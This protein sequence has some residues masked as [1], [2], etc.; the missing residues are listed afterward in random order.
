MRKSADTWPRQ[1]AGAAKHHAPRYGS[2]A[3]PELAVDEVPQAPGGEAERH[4]RRD[5]IHEAQVIDAMAP[6]GERHG[7]HHTEQPAVERHAA[8]PDGEDLERMRGVVRRL[9][10]EHVAQPTAEDHAENG[11]EDEIVELRA[12]DWRDPL[13]DAA[14]PE[15]PARRKAEQVHEPVPPHRERPDGKGDRI[16]ARMDEHG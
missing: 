5:E 6:D 2:D 7:E 1:V 4:E 15:P 13:G 16:D 10:E 12:R 11:E 9:V 8:L 3:A 14:Q